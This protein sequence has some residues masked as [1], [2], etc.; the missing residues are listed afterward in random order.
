[1]LGI[2]RLL[3]VVFALLLVGGGLLGLEAANAL[4]N[5]GLETH[6][7][8]FA[9][10]LMPAQ[11]DDFVGHRVELRALVGEAMLAA[12]LAAKLD[13]KPEPKPIPNHRRWIAANFRPQE[14]KVIA[15]IE[16]RA[17]ANAVARI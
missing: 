11:L 2:S 3:L 16:R 12:E 17:L 7:V 1:M 9:P 13:R 4:Q 15:E 10:R 14:I 5:L 6:V 8:E